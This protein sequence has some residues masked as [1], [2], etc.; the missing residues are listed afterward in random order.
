VHLNVF[1]R[2]P[3]TA[4]LND[5]IVNKHRVDSKPHYSI[6]NNNTVFVFIME[7][8]I[9]IVLFST[10]F[11]KS[12]LK[13]RMN[14]LN[15]LKAPLFAELDVEWAYPHQNTYLKQKHEHPTFKKI[16]LH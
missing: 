6:N 15:D 2:G 11:S 3:L 9:L 13:T 10:S 14:L 16:N 8:F 12:V 7:Y 5:S 1:L 4:L